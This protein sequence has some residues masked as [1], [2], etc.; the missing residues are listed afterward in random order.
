M[1]N[2]ITVDREANAIRLRRSY[3]SGTFLLVEGI[4]DK[5]FYQNIVDREK[6]E[7]VTVSGKP[8]SKVRVIQ[9][10][11]ILE[12]SSF[13][14]I[15]AIVDADF[16]H[17]EHSPQISPNLLLTDTHDLE[18][19]LLQSPA[20]EKVLREFGSEDKITKFDRDIRKLLLDLGL[21]IGYLRWISQLENL[22]LTFN[23][24]KFSKFIND[25]TLQLNELQFIQTVINKSQNSLLNSK[26]IQQKLINKKNLNDDPWQV[27]C[28][29]DLVEILSISLR[30]VLGTNNPTNIEANKLESTLRIGYEEA[31]FG[32][33]QL[34]VN[35]FTWERN[36]LPFEVLRKYNNP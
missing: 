22:N 25:K 16:D 31:Y 18:T 36:N 7:L 20:L 30:K 24:I 17:L 21:S 5:K 1:R 3:F 32:N 35:I 34:D 12:K 13:E 6:C 28:G 8:S 2:F 15:I 14:G 10:L 29:H 11:E 19:M 26:D 23:E 33:T 4:S 9:V 27:C